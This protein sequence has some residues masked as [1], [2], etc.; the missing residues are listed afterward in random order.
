MAMIADGDIGPSPLNELDELSG[1]YSDTALS[2][3]PLGCRR[4]PSPSPGHVLYGGDWPF[5]PEP[6]I[7]YSR[8][9][10]MPSQVLRTRG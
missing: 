10:W 4:W 7:G 6:L 2:S 8:M 5:A 9:H 3:S 1:F